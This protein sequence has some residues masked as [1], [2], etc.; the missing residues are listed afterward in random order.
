MTATEVFALAAGYLTQSVEDSEDLAPFVPGWLNVLLAE[1]LPTENQLRRFEGQDELPAA[2][3]V[4]AET[5]GAP[6]PY[7]EDILRTALPYGLASDFYRDDDNYYC[8]DFR[9]R[10]IAALGDVLRTRGEAVR[11]VY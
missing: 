7:H 2:P 9:A 4:T 8:Q 6:L 11:D 10:Y 1:C 5:M 3:R